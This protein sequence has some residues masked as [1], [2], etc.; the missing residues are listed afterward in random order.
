MLQLGGYRPLPAETRRLDQDLGYVEIPGIAG[1]SEF[2][3]R[4]RESIHSTPAPTVCG[5]MIDRRRNAG[6]AMPGMLQALRP[7]LGDP[8]IGGLV[9]ASGAT[10]AWTYPPDNSASPLR[11]LHEANPAVA[12][13]V[14]RLTAGAGE[15]LVVAFRGRANTRTFGEPTWGLGS[16][17]TSV[18]LPD[19][20]T[21]QLL[22]AREV[23]R[24]GQKRD[25]AITPD[26]LVASDWSRLN[27][28]DDP[29]MIAAGQWLRAQSSC[30]AHK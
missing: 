8:P 28:A 30:Q 15:G 23:D 20:A 24:N 7:I 1:G 3:A 9:D 6:G 18:P 27:A 17:T 10:M 21:L 4:I 19:G 22:T 14:G 16:G 25:G 29:I 12:L 2:A 13:L 5:W 11:A 26:Q